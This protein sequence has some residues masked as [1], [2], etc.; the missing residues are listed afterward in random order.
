MIFLP[1]QCNQCDNPA[2]AAVCPAKAI[3]KKANGIVFLDE[4]KCIGCQKCLTACPYGV[5]KFNAAKFIAQKCNLCSDRVDAKLNPYCV[6]V[7]VGGARIFGDLD[8]SSSAIA[9]AVKEMGATTYHPEYGTGPNIP[10]A[11]QPESLLALSVVDSKTG[12][13][14]VGANVT[15][16]NLLT[17]DSTDMASD[18]FGDVEAKGFDFGAYGVK[19]KADGYLPKTIG[20]VNFN[21]DMYLGDV[22]LTKLLR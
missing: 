15:L 8:D 7:C 22:K 6:D 17:G 18:F 16:T 20:F 19:V 4:T 2:C 13:M 3:S 1:L 10:Y 21:K 12:E 9:K 14:V 11:T 5:P